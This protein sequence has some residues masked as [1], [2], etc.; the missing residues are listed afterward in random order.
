MTTVGGQGFGVSFG[1]KCFCAYIRLRVRGGAT[2]RK[3]GEVDRKA[4][5]DGP[6]AAG[7]GRP[8]SERRYVTS[9]ADVIR[10]YCSGRQSPSAS[11]RLTLSPTTVPAD[12]ADRL[13]EP[14][15]PPQA[16]QR[17]RPSASGQLTVSAVGGSARTVGGGVRA[18]WRHGMA[19]PASQRGISPSARRPHARRA[20]DPGTA[21][22]QLGAPGGQALMTCL[23]ACLPVLKGCRLLLLL[24][25][26]LALCRRL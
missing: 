8:P 22:V 5:A 23:P 18:R 15:G 6:S 4:A 9:G 26:S 2:R 12:G 3:G 7:C 24:M 17:A 16:A 14:A 19:L 21:V 10:L 1:G 25:L 11:S 13:R 20:A